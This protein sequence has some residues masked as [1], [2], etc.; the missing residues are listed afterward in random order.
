MHM[1][2]KRRVG[3]EPD[4]ILVPLETD[5]EH[6]L[7]DGSPKFTFV[8]LVDGKLSDKDIGLFP[9]VIVVNPD[10]FSVELGHIVIMIVNDVGLQLRVLRVGDDQEVRVFFK[11]RFF[12]IKET[13][14]VFRSV[15]FVSDL[16]VFQPEGRRMPHFC[17][18][19]SPDGIRRSERV[20]EGVQRILQHIVN[21][22][23]V[24]V[25]GLAALAGHSAVA[26]V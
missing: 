10:I 19:R 3:A 20:L 8:S 23:V 18:V 6:G 1:L 14:V 15:I 5:H 12:E 22:F 25:I 26:D 21:F 13:A 9:V 2:E 24:E 16:K 4:L 7:C 17:A 11:D